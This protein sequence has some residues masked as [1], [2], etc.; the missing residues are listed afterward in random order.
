MG[1]KNILINTISDALYDCAG[2]GL[3]KVK[4]VPPIELEVPRIVE[5][6]D[7][8][9][10]IA[11]ILAS[12]EKKAPRSIADTIAESIRGRD[13]VLAR[14]KVAGPGFINLFVADEYWHN[15][16]RDIEKLGDAYGESKIGE[17]KRVQI[18]F[19]S[20]NP[21]G[22]IHVG[23]GRGA[24][25]GD[26]LANILKAVGYQVVTE[27][28]INDAGNQMET[29]GKSVFLRYMQLLGRD[30][31]LP[32]E[33]YQGEY[34]A[35]I[36]N[37]VI[38]KFGD[39]YL[40][41]P[42]DEAISDLADYAADKILQEIKEDLQDFGVTFDEWFSE[43][44]LF[45]TNKISEA[46]EELKKKRFL[47]EKDGAFWFKTTA[48]GDEKDRV[49]I[50]ANG[51]PTYFASDIA[52]HKDKLER[53]FDMIIN[54]WGA[55]HHGYIPR[56]ESVVQALGKGKKALKVLLVQLVNLLRDGQQVAM[57]TRSGEFDSLSEVVK[58]VGKDAARYFFLMRSSDS[59]LDFDLELAKKESAENPV[60]Y[61]QYAH[62]RISSILMLARERGLIITG[63]EEVE[64]D[65]LS[66]PEEITL[67]KQLL[68]F[69]EVIEGSA[70]SL[71]P[72]RITVHLNELASIFHGYYNKNRV[73]SDDLSMTAARL[74]LV[75][76]V[77]MVI[78]NALGLLGVDA[79]EKM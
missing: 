19:V 78:G 59:P 66:L 71:E 65:L 41:T 1:I 53:K 4:Q 49:V 35:D 64:V 7:F 34:I 37:E 63:C 40:D 11:M 69:P 67:I 43:K 54:V 17:G 12:A 70:V 26:V 68:K 77:K 28:Y 74:Y 10:N 13:T 32:S 56:I 61:A 24:A 75:K 14:V 52:Y 44:T 42:D 55:D 72:H 47:Y 46:T 76:T 2:K 21:T 51:R 33:C 3:L 9:T 36:A 15:S 60:Y 58:E 18:E 31:D 22:P 48:F 20:A 5:Y 50:R 16:L 23:H 73:I 8:S 79:P 27:Y 45:K 6:G 57:S 38:A 30:V 25:I 29:L 62:A 39:R